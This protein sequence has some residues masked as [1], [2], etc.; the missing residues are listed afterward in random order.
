MKLKKEVNVMIEK[1]LFIP[2]EANPYQDDAT[3]CNMT[4]NWQ[5][6]YPR[7]CEDCIYEYYY[8]EMKDTEG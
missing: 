2:E 6:C 4:G 1:T 3:D 7:Q 8:E 5:L